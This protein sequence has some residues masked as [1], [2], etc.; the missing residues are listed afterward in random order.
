MGCLNVETTRPKQ[1]DP[2]SSLSSKAGHTSIRAATGAGGGPSLQ[3][4]GLNWLPKGHAT[5][6]L[7]HPTGTFP[8]RGTTFPCLAR[9]TLKDRDSLS[10]GRSEPVLEVVQSHSQ[11]DAS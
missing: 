2:G 7:S 11:G 1:G 3:E 8:R 9:P 4:L 5:P 10:V 6:L